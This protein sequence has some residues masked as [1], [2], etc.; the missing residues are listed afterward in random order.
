MLC[1]K[2]ANITLAGLRE[3]YEHAAS[4]EALKQSSAT[5]SLCA[6]LWKAVL[7]NSG[8]DP[9]E[10]DILTIHKESVILE[11]LCEKSSFRLSSI[12]VT[13]RGEGEIASIGRAFGKVA[14]L[15]ESSM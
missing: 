1:N 2:C 8:C 12:L 9:C 6:V 7:T 11:G 14:L 10:E 15:V 3:T 4:F 5:C 13:S